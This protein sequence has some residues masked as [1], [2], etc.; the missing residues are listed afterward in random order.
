M[1]LFTRIICLVLI[2]SA[3]IFV[4][5]YVPIN[6]QSVRIP[7]SVTAHAEKITGDK[8]KFT[9]RTA[10]G[11]NVVSVRRPSARMLAAIDKG[12]SDLASV[13]RK[14]GF[15]KKT[16][17][18][19]YTVFIANTDRTKDSR[20]NYSPDIAVASGQYKDSVYDQGG[21]IYAAGMVVAYDPSAFVIAEHT[22][23]FERVS[24]VVRFEGEHLVLYHNDRKLFRQTADHS[25]GGGHPILK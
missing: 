2:L 23:D 10:K 21:F 14:N 17:F 1:N 6:S 3:L 8:F 4:A 18:S 9:T 11:V 19:D 25:Q 15:Y 12:F 5:F 24:D 16:D 20:G 7:P 22:S 13:A